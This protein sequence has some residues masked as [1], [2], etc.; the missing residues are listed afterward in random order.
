MTLRKNPFQ[1]VDVLCFSS[2]E[3]EMEL[4][5]WYVRKAD[6]EESAGGSLLSLQFSAS[7]TSELQSSSF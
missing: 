7:L 6:G 3:R 5:V 2:S 4:G 1:S